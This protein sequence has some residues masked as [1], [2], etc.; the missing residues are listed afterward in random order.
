MILLL[1]THIIIGLALVVAFLV[2]F[3]AIL[4]QRITSEQGRGIMLGIS[5]ALV[6]SGVALVIVAHAPLTSACLSS[7]A[8]IVTV[9]A[10]E[11]ALQL[12]GRRLSA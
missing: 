6:A 3:A 1:I 10:L 4:A 5:S 2:R 12:L 8:I 11:G 9:G 7:L